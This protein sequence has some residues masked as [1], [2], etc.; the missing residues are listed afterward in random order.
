MTWSTKLAGT[1]RHDS[2]RLG[3]VGRLASLIFIGLIHLDLPGFGTIHWDFDAGIAAPIFLPAGAREFP[4]PRSRTARIPARFSVRRNWQLE[5]CQN[6]PTRMSA[7]R[8]ERSANNL[9]CGF[10]ELSRS[11]L[12]CRPVFHAG[13]RPQGTGNW[14]VAR[15]RRQECRR[16][17]PMGQPDRAGWQ[18]GRVAGN[19][20]HHHWRNVW[21]L[22]FANHQP[23][24]FVWPCAHLSTFPV[25]IEM[26]SNG[27]G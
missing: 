8:A 17:H 19:A 13:S 11:V 23:Y 22:A 10:T 25:T 4:I 18:A 5:S 26:G 9:V 15:T 21:R 24:G 2:E 7:L 6:P 20:P 14:K 27:L 1:I 16:Y 12:R 3:W